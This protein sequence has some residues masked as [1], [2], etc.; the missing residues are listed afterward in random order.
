MIK[1]NKTAFSLLLMVLV[2]ASISC[3]VGTLLVRAPTPTLQA[4]RTPRPTFTF[5]P[6]WTPTS[7][8]TQTFT[9]SPVP[10]TPTQTPEATPTPEVPPTDVPTD[11]PVPPPTNTP[12]PPPPPTDTPVPEGPT[13]TPVPEYPYTVTPHIHDT[14]SEVET[15]VTAFVTEIEDASKGIHHHQIGYQIML[16]DPTGAE[17]LSGLSGGIN[18]ST[19]GGDNHLFNVEV[20]V[21]PYMA[22]HYRAWLVF[23]GVQQSPEIEFDMAGQPYQYVHLDFFLYH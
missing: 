14:G 4:T 19:G 17:H 8:P 21:S 20:K 5:T 15:R 23:N 6:D 22:G 11:T 2:L 16:I 18:E 9:P 7:T 3:S 1:Q 10:P 12:G 13:A